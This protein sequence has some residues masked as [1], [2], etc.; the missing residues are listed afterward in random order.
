MMFSYQAAN[1]SQQLIEIRNRKVC[2]GNNPMKYVQPGAHPDDEGSK[3]PNANEA[4]W[5]PAAALAEK[6]MSITVSALCQRKMEVDDE[7]RSTYYAEQCPTS[8]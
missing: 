7:N 4:E 6:P 2:T 5:R 1:K 3:W 8:G